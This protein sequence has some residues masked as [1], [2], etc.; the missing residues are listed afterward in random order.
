MDSR[1]PSRILVVDD[2]EVIRSVIA[3]VLTDDGHEVTEA[4]S[5]EEALSAFRQGEYPLVLTDIVMK[6][7]SGIELLKELKLIDPEVMVVVMTSHASVDTATS[8]LRSGAYDYLCKPFEDLEA[9]SSVVDRAIEKRQLTVQNKV[10]MDR[11]KKNAEELKD[12]NRSLR[13]MAM[14]DGL[15]GLY[16]HRFFRETLERELS[17]ADRHGHP[18]SLVFMDVDHFKKYNDTNGHL[19]GD[20]LLKILAELMKEGKRGSS[21]AARYG[22]EE[23]VMLIPEVDC[24]GAVHAA[25]RIRRR[26]EGFDFPHGQTQPMGRVTLSLGGASSPEHGK[27][28]TA[29][30]AAADDALYEAKNAGRNTVRCATAAD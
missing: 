28:A 27:D 9:I 8:A 13:D 25:E 11:L 6:R 5:A 21:I 12:L 2:E 16:N 4:A 19:A 7:M 29:L 10:L 30:I 3:E 22:G 14:R 23:F 17:R 20:E 1:T 18:F 26:V 24:A 15:T